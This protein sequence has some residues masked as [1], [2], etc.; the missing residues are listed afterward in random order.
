MTYFKKYIWVLFLISLGCSQSTN[1]KVDSNS[2]TPEK[3]TTILEQDTKSKVPAFQKEPKSYSKDLSEDRRSQ[4]FSDSQLIDDQIKFLQE[5]NHIGLIQMVPKTSNFDQNKSIPLKDL[6]TISLRKNEEFGFKP[7]RIKEDKNDSG[8][9]ILE[10]NNGFFFLEV[11]A[12]LGSYEKLIITSPNIGVKSRNGKIIR[13]G[14][15]ISSLKRN[16]PEA[17]SKTKTIVVD[18]QKVQST[19]ISLSELINQKSDTYLYFRHKDGI[20]IE[21][22]TVEQY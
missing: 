11:D 3:E 21:I 16:Y 20:I 7:F 13:V 5:D 1:Q 12:N 19:I 15:D 22:G 18:N 14:D 9:N 2:S 17:L 6:C 10:F 4:I 8:D